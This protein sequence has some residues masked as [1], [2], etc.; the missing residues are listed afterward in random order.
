[1]FTFKKI[2]SSFVIL[3]ILATCVPIDRVGKRVSFDAYTQRDGTFTKTAYSG[4]TINGR[5]RINWIDGDKIA[6]YMYSDDGNQGNIQQDNK[7]YSIVNITPDGYISKAKVAS[8]DPLTWRENGIQH[9]FIGIYPANYNGTF[10]DGRRYNASEITFNL[11]S[12]QNGS[13]DYAYMAA[14]SEWYPFGTKATLKFYSMVTTLYFILNNDTEEVQY[15]NRIEVK[16]DNFYKPLVGT[17]TCG[18]TTQFNP[19]DYN[20]SGTNNI[21]VNVNKDV[22][23]DNILEIPVFIIP[24]NRPTSNITANIVLSNK[25]LSNS[26][27]NQSAVQNFDAC[28]KYNIKINLSGEGTE[29]EPSIPDLPPIYIDGLEDGACQFLIGL[30]TGLIDEFRSI[31]GDNFINNR[32]DKIRG[33]KPITAETFYEYM[34]DNDIYTILSYFQTKTDIN[35]AWGSDISSPISAKDFKRLIPS[36]RNLTI[37]IENNTELWLDDMEILKTIF[38]DGNGKVIIHAKDCPELTTITFG[39][40]SK[41]KGSYVDVENC[42]KYK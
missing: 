26:F 19:Y 35:I 15:I 14:I 29:I 40:G 11:P 39:D 5:E 1:M 16:Q 3:F 12:N 31:L 18:G 23:K 13:M 22:A 20:Y 33:I 21:T 8:N 9:R 2:I 10:N 27:A 4:E 36:V 37:R 17:F 7:E 25:Q 42:P 6:I 28:R 34:T 24:A 41:N 38:V 30:I 32:F